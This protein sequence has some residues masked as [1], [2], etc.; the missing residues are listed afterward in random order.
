M[1]RAALTALTVGPNE[2]TA[3]SRCIYIEHLGK[4]QVGGQAVHHSR[5][6]AR[7]VRWRDATQQPCSEASRR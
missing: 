6:E 2:L 5:Q 1:G 3:D 4:G 7:N